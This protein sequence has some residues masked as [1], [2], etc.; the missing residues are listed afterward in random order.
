VNCWVAPVFTVA[1]SGVS[2]RVVRTG[3]STTVI[4]TVL[5][6][7]PLVTLTL[8]L[9]PV[10]PAVNKPLLET[11]PPVADQVTDGVPAITLPN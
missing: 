9:P 1:V 11:V 10:D 8:A 7:E 4:V 5:L 3:C 2:S 6:I